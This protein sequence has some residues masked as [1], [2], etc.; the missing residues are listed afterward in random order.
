MKISSSRHFIKNNN[1][2][3]ATPRRRKLYGV[4]KIVWKNKK[5]LFGRLICNAKKGFIT[6]V[7]LRS[8]YKKNAALVTKLKRN[9]IGRK[10][11]FN[12]S[13]LT[14]Y[15]LFSR[16]S[17]PLVLSKKKPLLEKKILFRIKKYWFLKIVANNRSKSGSK[18][19][20]STKCKPIFVQSTAKLPSEAV[21]K[22][23]VK[24]LLYRKCNIGQ[25]LQ[26]LGTQK[27]KLKLSRKKLYVTK[28]L[29]KKDQNRYFR[30]KKKKVTS[31]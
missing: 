22:K 8:N 23:N 11:L 26:I 17:L 25:T 10:T 27:I 3:F 1:K 18:L 9:N 5:I 16:S 28:R 13:D 12:Y 30:K 29:I 7:S 19:M 20:I 4:L 15:N 6:R 14:K 31:S 21:F 24:R 2:H